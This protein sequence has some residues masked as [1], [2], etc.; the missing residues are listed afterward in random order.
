MQATALGQ[1]WADLLRPLVAQGSIGA[2]VREL[3]LQAQLIGVAP[4]PEGGRVWR[5]RVA[6]EP[7]RAAPLQAKLA[8]ALQAAWGEPVQLVLEAGEALDSIALRDA[9][10]RVAAQHAAEQ[11]IQSDATVQSVLAAFQTARI[12]PGSV[13]PLNP[14]ASA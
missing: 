3:A 12:V 10:A 14:A 2:L 9:L 11:L 5:L 4:L 6:R 1:Q 13:K 8:A 7:L